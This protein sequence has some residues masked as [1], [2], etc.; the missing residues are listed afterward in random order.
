[1]M[2][3]VECESNKKY[4]AILFD[5][6][7]TLADSSKGA[8]ECVQYA[9]ESM[10]YKPASNEKVCK[11]I[12]LSLA[13][14]FKALTGNCCLSDSNTFKEYF[15][16]KADQVMADNTILFY[17][18]KNL[19]IFIKNKGLKCGIVSTKYRYRIEN[20]LARNGLDEQFD[21]IIGGEDVCSQKPDPEGLLKAIETLVLKK[22]DC[23]Y[24]G[25]S[26]IDA[27]TAKNARV[28]FIAVLT[29]TTSRD[30]FADFNA[31]HVISNLKEM[32]VV[33]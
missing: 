14:T 32:Q 8:C 4:K 22:S 26:T 18:V 5:F 2:L 1:M 24:V 23:L 11:T 17:D 6:D 10:G 25:D 9:L 31:I 20:I 12:G 30:E 29:G 3:T 19:I 16:E 28:D 21:I 27:R 13:D 7:Y 33:L 15:V